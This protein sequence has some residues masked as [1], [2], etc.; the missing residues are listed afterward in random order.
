MNSDNDSPNPF[1]SPET[2]QEDAAYLDAPFVP[3]FAY[4][5]RRQLVF[6]L[7]AS[8]ISGFLTGFVAEGSGEEHI[9]NLA[10]WL[11]S[12]VLIL[13]WC[14]I[15]REERQ[16]ARWRF[17]VPMMVLCPG[18]LVMIPAYLLVTRG[19]GGFAAIAKAIAFAVLM[20]IVSMVAVVLA[21]LISGEELWP[22][23]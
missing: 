19:L 4:R 11:V 9:I 21:L 18:P 2:S 5:K 13:R 17:F 20:V 3:N 14:D 6:L 8:G 16:L 23:V 1:Q 22:I 10:D 7:V 12:A 15:D